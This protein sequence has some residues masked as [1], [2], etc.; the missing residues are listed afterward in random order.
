MW[1]EPDTAPRDLAARDL[2]EL[3]VAA[4]EKLHADETLVESI[5]AARSQGHSFTELADRLDA[6]LPREAVRSVLADAGC[7]LATAATD[8]S[9]ARIIASLEGCLFV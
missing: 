2:A 8:D 5:R 3:D 4:R 7:G 1:S 6:V 9:W